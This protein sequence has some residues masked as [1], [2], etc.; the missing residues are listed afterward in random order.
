MPNNIYFLDFETNGLSNNP[1][2]FRIGILRSKNDFCWV[3]HSAENGAISAY[4]ACKSKVL[5]LPHNSIIYCHTYDIGMV[6]GDYI[7][8]FSTEPNKIIL[9]DKLY[10]CDY[11][12][13]TRFQ[14]KLKNGQDQ[15]YTLHFI[16]ILN[17]LNNQSLQNIGKIFNSSKLFTPTKF[18]NETCLE[19][20]ITDYDLQYCLQDTAIC[21][22][23]IDY[24]DRFANK[25]HIQLR[26]T[27]P[28]MALKIFDK[29]YNHMRFDLKTKNQYGL[30]Y[31][32]YNDL[33]YHHRYY[34]N[35]YAKNTY[36]GGISQNFI[37]GFYDN[38][39]Y[40][41]DI[42]SLYPSAMI[43]NQFGVG[44][45]LEKKNHRLTDIYNFDYGFGNF[46]IS[47]P[48]QD[49]PMIPYMGNKFIFPYGKNINV[50]LNL[51]EL[52]YNIDNCNVKLRQIKKLYY[53]KKTDTIFKEFVTEFYNSRIKSSLEI[54]KYF[55]K[56]FLNSLYGKYAFQLE[57][58]KYKLINDYWEL[59]DFITDNQEL[60]DNGTI[61]NI[62]LDNVTNQYYRIN[63]GK[64][65][66]NKSIIH[67]SSNI[68]SYSRIIMY[69]LIRKYDQH[70]LY[71]DTDSLF[72]NIELNSCDVNQTE[73]GKLKFEGKYKC[74][75]ILNPKHYIL[76]KEND[77]MFS[78][79]EIKIKGL[80]DKSQIQFGNFLQTDFTDKYST[81]LKHS[82][83]LKDYKYL[84]W[85][86]VNK[87]Y[88]IKDNSK[89]IFDNDID[90]TKQYSKSKPIEI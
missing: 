81:T 39:I 62:D 78:E 13:I 42:N 21:K 34:K 50:W 77:T 59:R 63:K 2:D 72:T 25:Y 24:L 5:S 69:Y 60:I 89:R 15:Y 80:K 36:R 18:K 11:V 87:H 30:Y 44:E 45:I 73:L 54:E 6:F 67:L 51:S 35:E 53:A 12:D 74:G 28:S 9:G 29:Q 90:F 48:Y 71:M 40:K 76:F 7:Q 75:F 38:S 22:Q 3:Y 65:L 84:D 31:D 43:N 85:R 56:I 46:V 70:I 41:Y 4:N 26:L 32:Y 10:S 68:T 27:I 55:F 83:Q 19:Y 14:K 1:I 57:D 37:R 79:P 47:V 82:Y 49:K 17:L 52:R 20:D 33:D 64:Q 88:N 23:Y 16:N 86:I 66:G 8:Y 61:T 58:I